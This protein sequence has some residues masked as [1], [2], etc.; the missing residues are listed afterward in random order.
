MMDKH[1]RGLTVVF[2]TEM[3]ERFGFYVLMAILVLYMN[4][5]LQW[6][7]ARKGDFYGWFLG[8]VYFFPLLGGWLG[9]RILGYRQTIR[10]GAVLLCFGYAALALSSASQIGWF[11]AGLVLVAVGTGVF[12]S[13]MSATVGHLYEDGSPLKDAAFNIYYMGVN[14]GAAIA[15]LVA[16]FIHARFNSYNI[17]FAA[18]SAGMI[19]A[20]LV[21][22]TG[23]KHL[24]VQPPKRTRDPAAHADAAMAGDRGED[25][26]RIAALF[27]LFVIVIFFWVAF[28]QNGFALTLFA[29]R[30]T[31]VSGI[32]R[33]ETYQ[34]FD[35]VFI[36]LLTPLVV[37]GFR[38]MARSGREPSSAFKIFLGM[39]ISGVSMLVMWLASLAGGDGDINVM[40]PLWLVASYLVLALGEIL[41]SAMG[42]SFVSKVAPRRLSGLMM[43]FWFVATSAGSYGAGMLGKSYS[44]MPHHQFFLL[45]AVLLFVASG[46]V[47]LTLKRLNRFSG[48]LSSE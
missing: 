42:L 27:T 5:E 40:S 48:S 31:V 19:L 7:D 12:K 3:W 43:G 36:L 47:L 24:P 15:P 16:T 20:I 22:E 41:V 11:Y 2:F 32:L 23:R 28:Y 8:A 26:K 25:G 46:M 34:F 14:I 18:A 21:F 44:M 33:P 9:D 30:S 6:T 17:S 29:A 4:D 35:P 10:L 45:I 1:P 37:S 39:A 13:N 38:R